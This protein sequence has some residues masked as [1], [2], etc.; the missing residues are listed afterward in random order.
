VVHAGRIV[1][2]DLEPAWRRIATDAELERHVEQTLSV[3][4]RHC[5]ELPE[6]ALQGCPDLAAVLAGAPG[7]RWGDPQ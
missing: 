1:G 6:R 4:L 5:A 7:A 3:A 2:V